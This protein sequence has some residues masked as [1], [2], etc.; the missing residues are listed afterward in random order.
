[1]YLSVN[2]KI[3]KMNP[4]PVDVWEAINCAEN[5]NNTV[6]LHKNDNEYLEA[7]V[8]LNEGYEIKYSKNKILY[9]TF[10]DCIKEEEVKKIFNSYYFD[11]LSWQNNFQWEKSNYLKSIK[12]IFPVLLFLFFLTL[13]II[14][15]FSA[16]AIWNK[17]LTFF[18]RYGIHSF[19]IFLLFFLLIL[20]S[21]WEYI[22]NFKKIS[23]Y[24]KFRIGT[25]FIIMP[26]VLFFLL[27][28]LIV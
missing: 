7:N 9:N 25:F 17:I 24:A 20:Y 22:R 14:N 3:V 27:M 13:W 19:W 28:D 21:D 15:G 4:L 1:M 26:I 8:M 12:N 18:N 6:S 23:N 16:K 10:L 11:D 5:I 2:G